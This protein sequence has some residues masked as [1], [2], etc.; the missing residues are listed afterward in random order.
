MELGLHVVIKDTEDRYQSMCTPL[1]VQQC[2]PGR[3]GHN[4]HEI[5]ML[6]SALDVVKWSI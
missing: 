1:N 3:F 2:V 5:D 4:L 6:L